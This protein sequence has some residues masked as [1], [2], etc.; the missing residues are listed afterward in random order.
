M[1][2]NPI[3]FGVAGKDG[4]AFVINMAT[5]AVAVGKIELRMRSN[6]PIPLGWAVG[7]DGKSTRDAELV[8]QKGSLTPLGGIDHSHKGY[9]LMLMVEALTVILAGAQYGP[10]I[11][12]RGTKEA[13]ANLG[14][15]FDCM[16]PEFFAPGY[17]NC[18]S[19]LIKYLRLLEPADP[20][21]PIQVPGDWE[22]HNMEI[23]IFQDGIMYLVNLIKWAKDFGS[24][25]GIKPIR[26]K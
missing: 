17:H 16:S 14:Q 21:R 26:P 20:K 11:P 3:S 19:C 13:D 12:P 6:K 22:S 24:E 4:D 7:P 5:T 10:F 18:I 2:T 15:C 23:N 25:H 8:F 9:R 1:E